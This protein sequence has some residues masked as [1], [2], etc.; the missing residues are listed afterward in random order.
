M[1][2][3]RMTANGR[4]VSDE[5]ANAINDLTE[6]FPVEPLSTE[7]LPPMGEM[8]PDEDL[9][10]MKDESRGMERALEILDSYEEDVPKRDPD[11]QQYEE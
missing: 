6:E 7:S 4:K 3:Y 10:K 8:E 1:K 2:H 5:E 9:Q 11:V